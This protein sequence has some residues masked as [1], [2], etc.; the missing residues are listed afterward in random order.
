MREPGLPSGRK[1]NPGRNL[2]AHEC[3]PPA[4]WPSSVDDLEFLDQIGKTFFQV[5]GCGDSFQ[6]Q[7]KL[8]HGESH[9]GLNPHNNSFC[10]TQADHVRDIP[11]RPGGERIQHIHGG[12]VHDDT[13]RTELDNL[14]EEPPAQILE[15]NVGESC[16]KSCDQVVSLLENGNFHLDL[17]AIKLARL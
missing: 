6:C 13:A 17:P 8:H 9:F 2:W 1:K 12:H 5:K 16:L 15:V 10:S 14:L 7:T 11:K 3:P 4:Q